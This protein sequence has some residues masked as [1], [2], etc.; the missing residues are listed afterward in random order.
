VVGMIGRSSF[1]EGMILKVC[2]GGVLRLHSGSRGRY[3]NE[4]DS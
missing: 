1:G 2:E 3:Q 4:L